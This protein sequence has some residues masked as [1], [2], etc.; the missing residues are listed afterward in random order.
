M[1]IGEIIDCLESDK[2]LRTSKELAAA[3][4]STATCVSASLRR[5]IRRGWVDKV[6]TTVLNREQFCSKKVPKYGLT[7]KYLNNEG[8]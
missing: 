1:G 8:M 6:M 5:L 3:T 7:K 4:G 2:K